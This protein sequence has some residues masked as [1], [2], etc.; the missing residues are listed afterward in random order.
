[1]RA[2]PHEGEGEVKA[3]RQACAGF[4]SLC[5]A[6]A[7][8]AGPS[9]AAE[10][11]DL[12]LVLAVDVSGSIDFEEAK[13]QRQGYIDA[14]RDKFVLEAIQSGPHGRIAVTYFEWS[15]S[16]QQQLTTKWAVIHDAA[17]ADAFAR[18][19]EDAPVSRGR[20][21]SISGAIVYAIPMFEANDYQARRKVID[22]SG[23]GPNN[24]GPWVTV[25]RELALSRQI[26]INGLPIINDRPQFGGFGGMNLKDLDVY[27]EHCVIGGPDAF[28]IAANGFEDFAKA[29]RRKMILEI[30]GDTPEPRFIP[31]QASPQLF[32]AT[33]CQVGEKMMQFRFRD[34]LQ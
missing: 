13:L 22:I 30:A 1:M 23:D 11:V 9:R 28:M 17:S 7:M 6:L 31:A 34:P 5:L 25:A 21:T 8:L 10:Q 15:G 24:A 32:E 18:Q 20:F 27:F 29:V 19:L 4:A 12:E 16:E 3:I 33:D 14:F 26:T 2:F